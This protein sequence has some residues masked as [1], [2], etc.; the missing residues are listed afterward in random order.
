LSGSCTPGTTGRWL[1]LKNPDIVGSHQQQTARESRTPYWLRPYHSC[2]KRRG[3]PHK[4]TKLR[5]EPYW[6]FPHNLKMNWIPPP[7]HADPTLRPESLSVPGKHRDHRVSREQCRLGLGTMGH[8]HRPTRSLQECSRTPDS[9][10]SSP[11]VGALPP[12]HASSS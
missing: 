12:K 10:P 7:G 6:A 3:H 11:G 2:L 9:N 4:R 1:R 8:N 5:N